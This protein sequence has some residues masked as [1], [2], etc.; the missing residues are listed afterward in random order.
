MASAERESLQD[1]PNELL[2]MVIRN[3]G[4]R[5][6]LRH[7]MPQR[8][9]A[10]HHLSLVNH[11]LYDICIRHRLKDKDIC[12]SSYEGYIQNLSKIG[13]DIRDEYTTHGRCIRIGSR[14]Q[15][16]NENPPLVSELQ[17]PFPSL[18]SLELWHLIPERPIMTVLSELPFLEKLTMPWPYN[19][20]FPEVGLTPKLHTLRLNIMPNTDPHAT[21]ETVFN[22][23]PTV[24]STITTLEIAFPESSRWPERYWINLTFPRLEVLN[25]R[26]M[27]ALVP[28]IFHFI[29][30][31]PTILEANINFNLVREDTFGNDGS[32]SIRLE[33]I[34][35]LIDGTGTWQDPQGNQTVFSPDA[36]HYF[37]NEGRKIVLDQTLLC[38]QLNYSYPDDIPNTYFGS[39]TFAFKRTPLT[40]GA[41]QWNKH[42]GSPEPRYQATEL[43]IFL[44]ANEYLLEAQL[45]YGHFH[46]FFLLAEKFP[47]LEV[48]RLIGSIPIPDSFGFEDYMTLIGSRL[49]PWTKLQELALCFCT[50]KVTDEDD[51]DDFEDKEN[52]ADQ[53]LWNEDE[54]SDAWEGSIL[55]SAFPPSDRETDFVQAE[56]ERLSTDPAITTEPDDD[57]TSQAIMKDPLTEDDTLTRMTRIW[58]SHNRERTTRVM[59]EIWESCPTLQQLDWYPENGSYPNPSSLSRWRFF[60]RDGQD[61]CRVLWDLHWE[62]CSGGKPDPIMTVLVGQE[63]ER[64]LDISS[65]EP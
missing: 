17:F 23:S 1:L 52:G 54:D 39:T 38:P 9:R 35:K 28:S 10:L 56:L 46:D 50:G 63:W 51:Y 15:L 6:G 14:S 53:F 27:R 4:R 42:E 64:E 47:A 31:H 36:G 21:L 62:G 49:K 32:L 29:H 22:A 33:A 19:R 57:V 44:V 48:L 20:P 55:D 61:P 12:F 58:R 41:T 34:I 59:R 65:M 26:G 37:T 3:L 8:W 45:P 43:S 24:L 18:R 25:L 40:P 11:R 5:Q 2:D 13:S 7:S 30:R 16:G 60:P